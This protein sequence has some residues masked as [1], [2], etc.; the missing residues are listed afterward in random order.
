[1]GSYT[2]LYSPK[3]WFIKKR[4]S[5][6]GLVKVCIGEIDDYKTNDL[7]FTFDFETFKNLKKGTWI[8]RREKPLIPK[9]YAILKEDESIRGYMNLY[10]FID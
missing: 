7:L 5:K 4:F 1:M 10:T 9:R 6:K 2:V 3:D 8:L